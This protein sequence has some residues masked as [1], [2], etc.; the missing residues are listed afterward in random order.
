MT[1]LQR[2][3]SREV[4]TKVASKIVT[5]IGDQR[6]FT[7]SPGTTAPVWVTDVEVGAGRPLKNVPIKSAGGDMKYAQRGRI[8]EMHRATLGRWQ[9]VGPGDTCKKVS[10]RRIYDIGTRA[11]VG[12]VVL[13]G[14]TFRQEP[15]EFY[16][17]PK[18]MK[19]NDEITFENVPA[20][21]DTITRDGGSWLDDGFL[22][23]DSV[24]ISRTLSNDKDDGS[25]ITVVT[26]L[27]A[28]VIQFAGDP[29]ADEV[30]ADGGSIGIGVVGTAL[31]DN[32][33]VYPGFPEV[34]TIDALGD[35]A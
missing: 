11:Q 24:S 3:I 10:E 15:F 19:G 33:G 7:M 20:A 23:G 31:W 18:A 28:L 34:T 21:N 12:G 32:G 22:A 29:F 8:V 1:Q 17:G 26:P 14:F 30:I 16:K 2:L 5:V 9:I 13:T 25:P 35:F 27:T 4:D 6:M